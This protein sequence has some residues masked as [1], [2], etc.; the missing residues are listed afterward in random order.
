VHH[1]TSPV[2]RSG[3]GR[4]SS[5]VI[6]TQQNNYNHCDLSLSV[7]LKGAIMTGQKVQGSFLTGTNSSPKT[8][9]T[10][11]RL[12]CHFTFALGL[13]FNQVNLYTKGFALKGVVQFWKNFC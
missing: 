13:R 2:A 11:N 4:V 3:L 1:L 7:P 12:L 6:H 5:S 10:P 9:N 8:L